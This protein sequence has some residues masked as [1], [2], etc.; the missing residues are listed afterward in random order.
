MAT[1]K[2][3]TQSSLPWP[4]VLSLAVNN[5]R[6]INLNLFSQRL[7]LALISLVPKLFHPSQVYAWLG[8]KGWQ[9][10][11]MKATLLGSKSFGTRLIGASGKRWV[12]RQRYRAGF[13]YQVLVTCSASCKSRS[14]HTLSLWHS[15]EDGG[16]VELFSGPDGVHRDSLEAWLDFLAL[17]PRSPQLL[18]DRDHPIITGLE[19]VR[20]DNIVPWNLWS[21]TTWLRGWSLKT[22]VIIVHH[23]SYHALCVKLSTCSLHCKLLHWVVR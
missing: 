22:R 5:V 13:T 20:V 10:L 18:I 8:W 4:T 1:V 21:I 2:P 17:H 23:F 16:P 14:H 3:R 12:R 15:Q 11:G 6:T 9:T 19:E 7:P